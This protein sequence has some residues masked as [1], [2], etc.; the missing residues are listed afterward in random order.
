MVQKKTHKVIHRKKTSQG[1]AIA[2]LILNI[3]VLPGLGSIVGGRTETGVWQL[4]LFLL[5]I[6]LMFILVGIPLAIG[7]WIWGVVTGIQ[8]IQG[9]EP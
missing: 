6:P 9:A 5:S 1:L 4:V 2:G 7:V 3:L 8:M